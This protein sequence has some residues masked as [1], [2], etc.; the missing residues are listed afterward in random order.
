[1]SLRLRA[2]RAADAGTIAAL[3]LASWRDAYRGMLDDAFLDAEAPGAMAA[4]WQAVMARRPLPGVVLLA[5][6]GHEAV[7][8][9]AAWKHGATAHVDNLHVR[10]GLRGAGIGRALIA[11]AAT[12]LQSRGCAGAD[13]RVFV[14]NAAAL[15]FYRGLGARIGPPEAGASFGQAVIERRCDWPDIGK[16]IAAAGLPR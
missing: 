12:R 9:C 4:H 8:F 6:L 11:E 13:L 1:M 3:H 15:R 14:G 5:K 16:L 2:A 7:G 10:P